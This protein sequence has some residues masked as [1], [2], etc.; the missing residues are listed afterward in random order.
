LR[1]GAAA[2]LRTGVGAAGAMRR[3]SHVNMMLTPY[4]LPYRQY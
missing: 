4:S 2:D 3:L 1:T